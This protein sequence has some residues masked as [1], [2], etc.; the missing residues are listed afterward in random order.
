MKVTIMCP[1]I[2]IQERYG[3]SIGASGSQ[4]IPLGIFYLAGAARQAGHVVEVFDAVAQDLT[5]EQCVNKINEFKPDVIGI[6]S[7]TV[8]FHRALEIASLLYEQ[9]NRVSAPLYSV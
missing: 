9:G 6:S 2:S 8:V 4:S 3:S 7:T 1:P 5:V